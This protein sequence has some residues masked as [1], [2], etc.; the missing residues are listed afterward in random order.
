MDGIGSP[1]RIL[2]LASSGVGCYRRS[3]LSAAG[4]ASPLGKKPEGDR[5]D[6]GRRRGRSRCMRRFGSA[7]AVTAAA[8]FGSSALTAGCAGSHS[9]APATAGKSESAAAPTAHRSVA[10]Y[11]FAGPPPR[12][13]AVDRRSLR[14]RRNRS[15]PVAGHVF[16]W[17]FSPER[18]RL[19]AG[20]DVTAELRL[21]DLKRLRVLG[22][23]P[24]VE[25]GVHGLVYA[26]TW[27]GRSRVLTAV[28]SP[29]C[30]GLGDTVVS[31]VDTDSLRVVWRR[32]LAGSLQAG[33]SYRGRFALVLGPKWAIGPSRLV[34]VQPNGRLR[35]LRLEQIRS[36]WQ[37]YGHGADRFVSDQWNPGLALDPASGRAFAVQAGA[38]LAQ[39]DLRRMSVRYHE[40]AESISLLGRL[41]DWLDPAAEAKAMEGP[42]RHAVWLGDGRLAVT[43][44]DYQASVDS[45]GHQQELDKPAGLKLIDTR[46]WS[47]HTLDHTTS[48]LTFSG[49][50]LFAFGTSWDSRTSKMSGSGLTAYDASGRKLYHRYG[51]QPIIG[52]EPVPRGVLVS[53]SRGSV[54]FHHQDLLQPQSGRLLGHARVNVELLSGDEPF[55]F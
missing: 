4:A 24:L 51:H 50:I 1:S 3:E 25:P 33:A 40:L 35:T 47:V 26:S 5:W 29:G 31:A 41:H 45:H 7:L 42:D 49:G 20:S 9:S 36:G 12:L 34:L 21:Y 10:L 39:V 52:V 19:A 43:G 11:G 27:A 6:L 8:V 53:G 55:W 30:C 13:Y 23:V 46:N 38:P 32:D 2:A 16:G 15:V 48:S 44:V 54:V 22:D 28:V 37:R 18:S 17:S 14:P